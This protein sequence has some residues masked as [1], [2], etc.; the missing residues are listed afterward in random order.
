MQSPTVGL[1]E[2]IATGDSEQ[3]ES[4]TPLADNQQTVEV[5]KLGGF[6]TRFQAA[7]PTGPPL[8]EELATGIRGLISEKLDEAAIKEIM[9]KHVPPE[10][11]DILEVPKVNPLIWE[12]IPAKTKSKDLRL[13]KLQRPLVKGIV[14]VARC[15]PDNPTVEQQEALALLAQTNTEINMYRR[16]LIKPDLNSRFHPLCKADVR[17]TKYLFGDDLGKVV[18]DMAEQQKAAT[19]TK[20][21]ASKNSTTSSTRNQYGTCIKKWIE[22]CD[23]KSYDT[24]STTTNIV[25]DFLV[26]LKEEGLSYSAINTARRSALAS[27]V[28]LNSGQA[29]SNDPL[30][31]RFLKGIFNLHPPLPRYKDIWDVGVVLQYLSSLYPGQEISLKELSLKLCSLIAL[32][33]AQRMQ[34]IHLLKIDQLKLCQ[35]SASFYITGLVE[36]SRPGNHQITVKLQGYP[37]DER[38]CVMNTLHTYLERTAPLRGSEKQLFISYRKPYLKVSKDTL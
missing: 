16:E 9:D 34:T 26:E 25:L 2:G 32:T 21:G 38:I 20:I 1:Q 15:F 18:K 35:S 14:A 29:I 10:N 30:I 23:E 6:A 3:D 19:V 28:V 8:S 7:P 27:F 22:D 33:T 31:S 24:M 11:L 5:V 13:Q 12:N 4:T 37:Q 17:V 36:Q